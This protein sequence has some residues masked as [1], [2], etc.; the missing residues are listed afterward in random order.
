M[1]GKERAF[2]RYLTFQ[3]PGWVL[4]ACLAWWLAAKAGLPP[5]L[6]ALGWALFVIKDFALYPWLR[7]AYAVG[8]PAPAALLVGKTGVARER[9][10]PS[11]YVRVGAE[12]WRAELAP[13]CAAID[14]GAH[15]RV[16]EV[17]GLTLIV[18][19]VEPQRG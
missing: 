15:V 4:T 10:D 6:A 18:D 5:W 19:P 2:A 13:G 7:D 14:T 17:Q 8:E 3:V 16:L 9:I 1:L 11:G 12:L